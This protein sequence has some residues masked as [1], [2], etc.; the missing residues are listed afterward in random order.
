MSKQSD[1]SQ[2]VGVGKGNDS[3]PPSQRETGGSG[4][5]GLTGNQE[6]APKPPAAPSSKQE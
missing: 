2:S 1:G 3:K 4:G 5:A 6:S